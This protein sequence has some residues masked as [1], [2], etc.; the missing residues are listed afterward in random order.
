MLFVCMASFAIVAG[1]SSD[2]PD[3]RTTSGIVGVPDDAPPSTVNSGASLVLDGATP[4]GPAQ[5][6]TTL[7]PYE[8]PEI[9][10]V[11]NSSDLV[12]AFFD[13]LAANQF[14]RALSYATGGALDLVNSL[15]EN[16]ICDVRVTSMS[17]SAPT[18]A[19]V[20]GKARY[21]TDAKATLG[22]N[23]G[24]TQQITAV[25]VSEAK[26]GTFR[27]DD[28]D[29]GS[30]PLARLLDIGRGANRSKSEVRVETVDLCI[31]PTKAVAT[32]R[33]LN[34]SNGP[35]RP[36][37]T[38]FRRTDGSVAPVTKGVDTILRQPMEVGDT[39][40]WTVEVAGDRLW[41]GSLVMIAPDLE[42]KPNGDV[43]ERAWQFVVAPFF[44]G[45]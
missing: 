35:I 15:K 44:S 23:T 37:A 12:L 38:F 7:A 21:R 2:A 31:G 10:A 4:Q 26:N 36:T 32:F 42:G 41:N 39:V 30:V 16:Q 18:T 45:A 20:S 11:S 22:F 24:R 1:C 6:T 8:S 28:F 43:V 5:S 29:L 25:Y 33:A 9:R 34:D 14:E 27:I 40:T 13:A 3:I 19:V 17:R